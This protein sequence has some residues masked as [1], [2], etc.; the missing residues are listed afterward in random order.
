MAGVNSDK[1][2]ALARNL[3]IVI[4]FVISADSLYAQSGS[5]GAYAFLNLGLTPR[6]VAA[7]GAPMS[8]N[9][10]DVALAFYNP[11]LISSEMSNKLSLG[12][13]DY[14]G[15]INAGFAAYSHTFERIGSITGGIQF[16]NYGTFQH[17]DPNG[18][19]LGEFKAAD[20]AIQFG[21]G[22][23]LTP[24]IS[25]GANTKLILSKLE[26][27]SSSAVAVDLALAWHNENE[28]TSVSLIARNY[29]RQLRA[30]VPGNKEELPSELL[31]SLSH[32]LEK[33]PI[34]FHLAATHLD[35]WDLTY[36]DPA[37]PKP[38]VDPL[39]GEKLPERKAAQFADKLARHLVAGASLVPSESFQL[40][41]GYN[42][43]RRQE[44]KTESRPALTGF[45]FGF[46][47]KSKKVSSELC[48][49][50]LSPGRCSESVWNLNKP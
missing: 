1:S 4:L 9:D 23:M 49:L 11:A 30:Y 45:S 47:L 2:T 32:K 38:T 19:I 12:Y 37:N 41:L 21:W 50:A 8:T 28:L 15:D 3:V 27:Y 48:P 5:K 33:A 34:R 42:Y 31:L 20:Y 29:G 26:S 7:G 39:T 44:L 35:T 10:H 17:T 25:F 13:T 46:G 18:M 22:K 14:F 36:T 40:N 43:L 6:I 24:R 16:L